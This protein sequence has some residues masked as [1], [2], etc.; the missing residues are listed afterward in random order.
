MQ[1]SLPHLLAVRNMPDAVIPTQT[2]L[3]LAHLD[4]GRLAEAEAIVNNL[5][6]AAPGS[7]DLHLIQA[8]ILREQGDA[9]GALQIFTNVLRLGT[10]PL[11]DNP[12]LNFE[13][14][15]LLGLAGRAKDALLFYSKAIETAPDHTNALNNCAW[16]LA[17]SPDAAVR[18]GA[19][20]VEYAERACRLSEWK[21]PVLIGTLGAAYAEAGQ[22]AEA[23]KTAERARDLARIGNEENIAMKNQELIEVYRSGRPWREPE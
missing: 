16:V 3:A 23:I 11:A 2:R 8:A 12:T 17:T 19:R 18:N 7:P 9:A 15:E 14:A 20:A 13:L 5:M 1:E 21:V 10:P 22:F 6:Q 4:A